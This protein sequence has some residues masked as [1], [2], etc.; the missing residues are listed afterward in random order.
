MAKMSTKLRSAV[1][2]AVAVA[3]LGLGAGAASAQP[4]LPPLPAMPESPAIPGIS[5]PPAPGNKEFV[6]FGDSFTANAGKAGP[7]GLEPGQNPL[8]VNCATDMENWP[9][10]AAGQLNMSVG[11]WSCNGTGGMPVVQL[12]AY[13]EAAIAQGDLGPGTKEVV[14]MYGGMDALQWV[15]VGGRMMGQ[16]NMDP[17]VYRDTMR[18][19]KD[20]VKQVAPGARVTL[21]SYPEYATG[22]KL[23]LVNMPGQTFPIDAPGAT[24]IQGAFRDTIRSAAEYSGSHFIDV[25]QQS[26]GH[27][28][29]NPNDADRWVAGFADPA[30]GPMTNHPTIAG[31]YAMGNI[32]AGGLR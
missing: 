10:I 15:D 18:Q 16:D 12:L 32:I 17:T 20:R 8:V 1:V 13:V 6:A 30:L 2:A 19:V 24:Q 28:T 5:F 9:K 14:L 3:G 4:A 21:T 27:G 22:D 26:I 29:C 23:C 31:E 11:D 25:Y 7:R